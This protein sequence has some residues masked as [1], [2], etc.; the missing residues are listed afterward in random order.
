MAPTMVV[1]GLVKPVGLRVRT[2]DQQA[3]VLQ[4][5]GKIIAV[6]LAASTMAQVGQ[7]PSN[8]AGLELSADGKTAYVTPDDLVD[9]IPRV[10]DAKRFLSMS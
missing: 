2:A 4:K 1:S 5:D 9:N 6:D 8:A 7:V 10:A 3:I